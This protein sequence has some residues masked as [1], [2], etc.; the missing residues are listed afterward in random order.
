MSRHAAG[1]LSRR[2]L[3]G[4]CWLGAG[5]TALASRARG[6]HLVADPLETDA[7]GQALLVKQGEITALELVDAAIA[8]IKTLNPVLNAVV[9]SDF[10][11]ARRRAMTLDGAGAF[12][13]VP[14]LVKDLAD[15][16]D[17]PTQYGSRLFAGNRPDANDPT[18]DA[19][20]QAGMIILGKTATPEFGLIGTT[21]SLLTGPTANPWA[22]DRSP[23]GS[24][25]GAGA[26]IGSGMVPIASGSDG[27]GSIR[28]PASNCGVFG[29]KPSMGVP[30][31]SSESLPAGIAVRGCLSRSVRD[32]AV[33]TT[34]YARPGQVPLVTDPLDRSLKVGLVIN[35]HFGLAPHPDVAAATES[36]GRLLESLGHDVQPYSFRFDGAEMMDHFMSFWTQEPKQ[37]RDRAIEQGLDPAEVLE[38]WTLG[39]ARMG[40]ERGDEEVAAAISYLNALGRSPE[41]FGDFDVLLSPVL[42]RPPVRTGEQA[43]TLPFGPLYEDVLA[44]VS[45]TP[46]ANVAG[47]AAMS[48]PL[49]WSPSGLPIGSQVLARRG[50]DALLLALAYQLEAARPWSRTWAPYSAR[51]LQISA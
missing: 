40:D 48:V 27:G 2:R 11:L 37:L 25:G 38:P 4:S 34:V 19:V 20:E 17:F 36:T 31:G 26:A 51:Y 5:L 46:V 16:A 3:L 21:E 23:G 12:Q 49:N 8:R 7:V 41:V 44:Y 18:V 10:E 45:Y 24:S 32:S 43:P 42:S 13:G 39:L 14:Y 9:A 28:L 1:G 30:L 47:F 50:Q 6:A 22:L 29:L 35:D 33:M 15:T